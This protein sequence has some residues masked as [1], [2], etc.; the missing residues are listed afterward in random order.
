MIASGL[1]PGQAVVTAGVNKL[2]NGQKVKLLGNEMAPG[3]AGAAK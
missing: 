3:A 1:A 2:K